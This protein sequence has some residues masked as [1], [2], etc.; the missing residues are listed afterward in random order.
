MPLADYSLLEFALALVQMGYWLFPSVFEHIA[1]VY[2]P[3][4]LRIMFEG[5]IVLIQFLII[6]F[7][8]VTVKRFLRARFQRLWRWLA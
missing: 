3:I 1:D 6:E 5:C 4:S 7:V 2:G 8:V